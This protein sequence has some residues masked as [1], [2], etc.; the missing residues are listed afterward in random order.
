MKEDPEIW[1]GADPGGKRRF[2]I[3]VLRDGC[4]PVLKVVGCAGD[5]VEFVLD[6]LRGEVPS[7]VGVDAPLWWPSGPSG[8]R[9]ADQWIRREYKLGDDKGQIANSLRG[10]GLIQGVML[11][12]RI[13]EAC[14]DSQVYVTESHPKSLPQAIA[15]G[16]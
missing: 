1:V 5:G 12:H 15:E 16:S 14:T 3:A 8:D 2:G 7:G 13:R 6:E 11:A 10:T 4:E 9:K